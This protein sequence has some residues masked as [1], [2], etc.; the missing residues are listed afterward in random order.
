MDHIDNLYLND[1]QGDDPLTRLRAKSHFGRPSFQSIFEGIKKE[2]TN[3]AIGV[4][5]SGRRGLAENIE[6][7]CELNSDIG[8]GTRF[9]FESDD[10]W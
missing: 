8:N 3:T 9:Y 5:F 1:F 7:V 6:R 2:H 10:I 4:Y